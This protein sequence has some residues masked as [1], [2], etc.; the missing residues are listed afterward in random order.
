MCKNEVRLDHF[1]A[2]LKQLMIRNAERDKEEWALNK[3]TWKNY[4]YLEKLAQ[5]SE[6]RHK[7]T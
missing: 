7:V 2:L 3:T 6:P 1:K 4:R 5:G